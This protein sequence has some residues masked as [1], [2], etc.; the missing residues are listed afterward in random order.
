MRRHGFPVAVTNERIRKHNFAGERLPL[1]MP[2]RP[3]FLSPVGDTH[4][5]GE[6]VKDSSRPLRRAPITI[7]LSRL[8]PK[9]DEDDPANNRKKI[10]ELPPA[11]SIGIVQSPRSYRNAWQKRRDSEGPRQIVANSLQSQARNNREQ[12]PPPELR[13]RC[14]AV[15]I[16]ILGETDFYR[17][18]KGHIPSPL[19]FE[20]E[21]ARKL[22]SR[23]RST[24][25]LP[26]RYLNI[27]H[28]R[29][30]PRMK[31][32]KCLQRELRR[33]LRKRRYQVP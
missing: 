14:A 21:P 15:E 30:L 16:R 7:R 8:R 32:I 18:D 33:L 12:K 1:D 6:L 25:S 28:P 23:T 31:H 9:D 27:V 20:R 13:P 26:Q 24:T 17:V 22:R 3:L 10:E 19:L 2:H 4:R 29:C 11:T 5:A